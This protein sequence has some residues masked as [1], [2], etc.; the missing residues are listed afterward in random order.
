MYKL[1]PLKRTY[2]MNVSKRP[3]ISS[4][5]KYL[6]AEQYI[7]LTLNSGARSRSD[8][9]ATRFDTKYKPESTKKRILPS[10]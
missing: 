5:N 6:S 10:S 1:E 3:A 2:Q 7:L 8:N 9:N 4:H